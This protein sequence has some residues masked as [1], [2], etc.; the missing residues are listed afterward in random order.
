MCKREK[1][2]RGGTFRKKR[3]KAR[4]GRGR[5]RFFFSNSNSYAPSLSHLKSFSLP[6]PPHPRAASFCPDSPPFLPAHDVGPHHACAQ[7]GELGCRRGCSRES[8]SEFASISLTCFLLFFCFGPPPTAIFLLLASIS[9][10]PFP[11]SPR[12]LPPFESIHD[13]SQNAHFG[14]LDHFKPKNPQQMT[15]VSANRGSALSL[16]SSSSSRTPAAARSSAVVVAVAR[17]IVLAAAAAAETSTGERLRL[18]NLSPAPG[19][20]RPNKRKGRGH[21]SGQV[22]RERGR[23]RELPS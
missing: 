15:S 19:S 11:A 20:R 3:K 13:T 14:R 5:G 8:E 23:E 4:G 12:P 10:P 17:P 7:H 21:A 1:E 22:R 6:I 16:P 2:E 18:G 9:R